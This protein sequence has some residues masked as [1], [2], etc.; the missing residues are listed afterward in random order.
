MRT[1]ILFTLLILTLSAAALASTDDLESNDANYTVIASREIDGVT[2]SIT[3]A[4][5]WPFLLVTYYDP[6]SPCF[7]G[8]DDLVNAPL[9]PAGVS[10]NRFMSTADD[11]NKD[12][13][14]RFEFSAP[15]E[16]FGMT[17]IDV[18][19][20]VQTSA[21]AEVRLIGYHG[22]T[23]VAEHVVTGI[24][25]LSGAVVHWEVNSSEGITSAEFVRTGGTISAGYGIDDLVI[26]NMPVATDRT[27][28]DA[29]KALYR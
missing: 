8:A 28:F 9:A 5:N 27:S 19:E 6:G 20:D 11:I 29:V 24:Q 1:S 2:V 4:R 14:I 21:D 18:L 23:V 22:T 26:V 7:L 25:D 15:V 10:G 12:M 17:T 16:S 3:N 13:P